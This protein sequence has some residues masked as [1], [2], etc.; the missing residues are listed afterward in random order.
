MP[1]RLPRPRLTHGCT[2]FPAANASNRRRRIVPVAWSP[3]PARTEFEQVIEDDRRW[4]AEHPDQDQYI[5]ELCPSEFLGMELPEIPRGFRHA[6]LVTVVSRGSNGVACV[7][8]RR[9]VAIR[10][11]GPDGRC[12]A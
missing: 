3:A 2:P 11:H 10:T 6:T 7:R 12:D 8:G 9:M 5:R 4:F 1:Y